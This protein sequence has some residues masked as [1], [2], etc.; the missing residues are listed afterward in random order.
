VLA[1]PVKQDGPRPI[2]L[3]PPD[4]PA[5]GNIDDARFQ[6]RILQGHTI[7]NLLKHRNGSLQV[8]FGFAVMGMCTV[9]AGE[10]MIRDQLEVSYS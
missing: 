5:S 7:E 10:E 6:F 2:R 4:K 8:Y 3:C 1:R 9:Y